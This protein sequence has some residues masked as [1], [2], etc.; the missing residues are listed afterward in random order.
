MRQL[1]T[2]MRNRKAEMLWCGPC[3]CRT[4]QCWRYA[5]ENCGCGDSSTITIDVSEEYGTFNYAN[6]MWHI[7]KWDGDEINLR[8]EGEYEDFWVSI[9]PSSFED[10]EMIDYW[11]HIIINDD[12]YDTLT[13]LVNDIEEAYSQWEETISASSG[14][15][16]T[17]TSILNEEIKNYIEIYNT[18]ERDLEFIQVRDFN[19]NV[20]WTINFNRINWHTAKYVWTRIDELNDI[21]SNTLSETYHIP[22]YNLRM[23][24]KKWLAINDAVDCRY[25]HMRW[26]DEYYTVEFSDWEKYQIYIPDGIE[27]RSW[28]WEG[29]VRMF[30]KNIIPNPPRW[31]GDTYSWLSYPV[32]W[33]INATMMQSLWDGVSPWFYIPQSWHN[34]IVSHFRTWLHNVATSENSWQSTLY[35]QQ[36]NRVDVSYEIATNP[37]TGDSYVSIQAIKYNWET[38]E[39]VEEVDMETWDVYFELNSEYPVVNYFVDM[40]RMRDNECIKKLIWE[41]D[42]PG[43]YIN[44]SINENWDVEEQIEELGDIIDNGICL[45]DYY[46]TGWQQFSN[47]LKHYLYL[48]GNREIE[49][50]GEIPL[51]LKWYNFSD[52]YNPGY[53][54]DWNSVTINPWSDPYALDPIVSGKINLVRWWYNIGCPFSIEPDP[55]TWDCRVVVGECTYC[56]GG[57]EFVEEECSE[58]MINNIETITNHLLSLELSVAHS[59]IRTSGT[60]VIWNKEY[61]FEA[62]SENSADV[63]AKYNWITYRTSISIETDAETW[64]SR[65]VVGE[66]FPMHNYLILGEIE[67]PMFREA[68][69]WQDCTSLG[70][71]VSYPISVEANESNYWTVSIDNID[72]RYMDILQDWEYVSGGLPNTLYNQYDEILVT[73]TPA[74]WYKLKGW[75]LLDSEWTEIEFIGISEHQYTVERPE[76]S[77]IVAVFELDEK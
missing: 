58:L 45:R 18:G 61:V 4:L 51:E 40:L 13:Q 27:Y 46:V 60:L 52:P 50:W 56:M 36:W 72:I 25:E 10:I 22:S 5:N 26:E 3:E 42:E 41:L 32:D 76:I 67:C 31:E 19:H 39:F 7:N 6:V 20:I 64:L 2:F 75:S 55:E 53:A 23:D 48:L 12:A 69:E 17:I 62:T 21:L 57:T 34:N 59:Y 70:R 71:L 38:Q 47:A 66:C 74:E 63:Y 8:Y 43:S 14:A 1:K 24:I 9:V 54:F 28:M 65:I 44:T 15:S 73:A 37:E 29:Y 35:T 77:T 11:Q 33:L 30:N 68:I 16:Q 49:I